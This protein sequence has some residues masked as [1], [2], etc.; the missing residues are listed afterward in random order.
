MKKYLLYL[1]LIITTLFRLDCQVFSLGKLQTD[2]HLLAGQLR[3]DEFNEH[4]RKIFGDT[5]LALVTLDEA[6]GKTISVFEEALNKT[7]A[8]QKKFLD[9]ESSM[10]QEALRGELDPRI[11]R[12][13][14]QLRAFRK[15]TLTS[16]EKAVSTFIINFLQFMITDLFNT[17]NFGHFI[18]AV[19]YEEFAR[20]IPQSINRDLY[21]RLNL[22]ITATINDF[23]TI[24][25]DLI[26]AYNPGIVQPFFVTTL[27]SRT[28]SDIQTVIM[29]GILSFLTPLKMLLENPK[30][31]P[32]Y[33][34]SIQR[35]RKNVAQ[36]LIAHAEIKNFVDNIAKQVNAN[37]QTLIKALEEAKN[38]L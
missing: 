25:S 17:S 16:D 33:R 21:T 9:E 11:T 34:Q 23:Q 37:R 12:I 20:K 10:I 30:R 27:E 7:D 6:A 35:Y 13:Q 29:R 38:L 24:N 2:L 19:R 36:E 28:A 5:L 8:A 31:L 14:R 15:Q 22:P 26:Q 3:R 4:I 18:A 32:R 1:V